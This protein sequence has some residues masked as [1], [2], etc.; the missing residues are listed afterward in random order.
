MQAHAGPLLIRALILCFTPKTDNSRTEDTA[1]IS[2][3]TEPVAAV[4]I[5]S[6]DC[7]P[8]T[9]GVVQSSESG[10]P[11]VAERY[12]GN[13]CR[14]QLLGWQE[15]CTAKGGDQVLLQ[16]ADSGSRSQL[17]AEKDVAQLLYFLSTNIKIH[18]Y[19]W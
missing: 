4:E 17:E 10:S 7:L 16:S 8:Y 13:V 5:S 3:C 18:V 15:C 1:E 2:N 11:C 14:K 9:W 6:D 12:T 19:I